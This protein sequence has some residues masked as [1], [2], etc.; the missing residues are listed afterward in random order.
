MEIIDVMD[1]L[2]GNLG[3]EDDERLSSDSMN[4]LLGW[5]FKDLEEHPTA[6][7]EEGSEMFNRKASPRATHKYPTPLFLNPEAISSICLLEIEKKL[8]NDT[9]NTEPGAWESSHWK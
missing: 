7:D 8:P 4:G 9:Y 3:I 5:D 2:E 1:E 6:E